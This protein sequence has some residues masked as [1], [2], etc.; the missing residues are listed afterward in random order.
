MPSGEGFADADLAETLKAFPYAGADA[1]LPEAERFARG[2]AQAVRARLR[3]YPN[4]VGSH[5]AF[6]LQ[7]RVPEP[8][9]DDA[10]EFYALD[11]GETDVTTGLWFV[12]ESVIQG[13]RVDGPDDFDD[14]F[15]QVKAA[16]LGALPA[17]TF[18]NV[19]AGPLLRYYPHG[20]DDAETKVP[21]SVGGAPVDLDEILEIVDVV[22]RSTL[23]TPSAHQ[24]GAK[25]WK[26][27]SKFHPVRHVETEIQAYLRLGLSVGLP[28]CRI[29][30]E[31]NSEAGRLDLEVEELDRV[32]NTVARHAILELK[33]LRSFGSTGAATSSAATDD[34]VDSGVE[35]AFAYRKLRGAR[36]AALCCFDMRKNAGDDACFTKVESKAK[37]LDVQLASWPLYPDV[38]FYRS[39]MARSVLSEGSPPS[40]T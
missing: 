4:D 1:D 36:R 23:V 31:Q 39:A 9:V 11:D 22:H 27:R 33:V 14:M 38:K 24:G 26:N 37:G 12:S 19:A 8:L 29:N 30:P 16:G 20:L 28:L 17:V 18:R 32:T 13:S 35:Q 3:A 25:L 40:P 10:V 5:A 21:M 15:R 6:V 2:V 34:W 7:P